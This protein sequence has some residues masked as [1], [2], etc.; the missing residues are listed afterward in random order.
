[1]IADPHLRGRWNHNTHHYRRVLD[2]APMPCRRALDVGCGDGLL[3]RALAA[4]CRNVVGL[5]VSH[6]MVAE[7]RGLVTASNVSFVAADLLHAPFK[8]AA[9]DLIASVTAIHHMPFE[10]AL[11]RMAE[12]LSPGGVLVVVG[13]ANNRS[14]ADW[15]ISAAGAPAHR[16]LAWR[17][18]YWQHNAP[19][20]D[21][22]MTWHEVREAAQR[23][24]PGVRWRRHLL[25][26]YS[27]V[28][29]KP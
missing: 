3:V 9:F 14:L 4:R 16:L 17:R 19:I 22:D 28:W 18:G 15:T 11:L 12:L 20:V 6:H 10:P 23:L 29:T 5:D 7:A 25:W 26:R 1:L 2:A 24:L 13:L 8:A 27:L 21:P